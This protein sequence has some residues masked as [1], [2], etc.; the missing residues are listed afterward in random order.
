MG[1]VSVTTVCLEH[2]KHDPVPQ[3]EY[4]IAP[5]SSV[6][7]DP[8]IEQLCRLMGADLV[9]SQVAQA[10]AW[11]IANGLSW[12][13]LLVKNRIE[14]MDGSFERFFA[15]AEL[16]AA[17]NV[18]NWTRTQAALLAAQQPASAQPVRLNSEQQLEQL[19]Q[20]LNGGAPQPSG[21]R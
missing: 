3:M 16:F 13:E 6:N 19:Q 10:A 15:P 11:H 1:K 17:Q 2:G 14:R 5:L 9:N 4:T 20:Q 8:A 7:S 21:S 12:E 18:T